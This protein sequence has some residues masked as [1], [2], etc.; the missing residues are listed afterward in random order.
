MLFVS[1]KTSD[2]PKFQQRQAGVFCDEVNAIAATLASQGRLRTERPNA[3]FDAAVLEADLLGAQTNIIDKPL[4]QEHL[5]QLR[6]RRRDRKNIGTRPA[7]RA[8]SS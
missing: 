2:L 3:G 7:S 8:F 4:S 1:T 6:E 5:R